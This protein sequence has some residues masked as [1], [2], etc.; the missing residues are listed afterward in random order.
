MVCSTR[1]RVCGNRIQHSKDNHGAGLLLR[2]DF[3]QPR[4]R[5][6]AEKRK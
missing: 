3:Q 1:K 2:A 5:A 4:G 6:T